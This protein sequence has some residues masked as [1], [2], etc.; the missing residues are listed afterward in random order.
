MDYFQ[1]TISGDDFLFSRKVSYD[2]VKKITQL[3]LSDAVTSQT[4]EPKSSSLE[5]TTPST[6][7]TSLVQFLEQTQAQRSPDKITA[8]IYYL[9]EY[10]HL[11]VST[12]D[13]ISQA[14]EA[15]MLPLPKNLNRDIRWAEK[16]GW[17]AEKS[18]QGGFYLT[19]VGKDVVD[20][21]FPKDVTKKTT[22]A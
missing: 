2:Q 21:H 3:V 9:R 7:Q 11:P 6:S 10:Q 4:T 14:F 13:D 12:K 8:I 17:I 1:I 19:T 5:S 22:N 15:A 18:G 16:N 20:A